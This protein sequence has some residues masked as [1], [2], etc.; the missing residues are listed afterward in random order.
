M[1]HHHIITLSF[2]QESSIEELGMAGEKLKTAIRDAHQSELAFRRERRRL[3]RLFKSV[4]LIYETKRI[5]EKRQAAANVIA[6]QMKEKQRLIEKQQLALNAEIQR[7]EK[8]ARE[9]RNKQQKRKQSKDDQRWTVVPAEDKKEDEEEVEISAKKK[10]IRFSVL[11]DTHNI[12]IPANKRKDISPKSKPIK[13]AKNKK[14][15][16]IQPTTIVCI[17]M[18]FIKVRIKIVFANIYF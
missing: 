1:A 18:S 10:K 15:I 14:K 7:Q 3:I 12:I 13:K 8:M 9:L 4:Q 11:R 6:S 17:I 16:V 5:D 2:L